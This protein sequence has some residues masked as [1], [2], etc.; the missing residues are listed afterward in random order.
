MAKGLDKFSRF[1]IPMV[2][3]ASNPKVPAPLVACPACEDLVKRCMKEHD[4]SLL[5]P[6][7]LKRVL[8]RIKSREIM[9]RLKLY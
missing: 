1:V 7:R 8:E 5:P 9:K 4:P 2:A 3:T 6:G